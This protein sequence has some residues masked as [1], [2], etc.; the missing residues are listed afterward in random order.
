MT[1]SFRDSSILVVM[2][3]MVSHPRPRTIGRTAF[4]LSPIPLKTLSTITASLGRYPE[5]SRKLKNTKKK[6]TMGST[7][8]MA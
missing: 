6:L 2:V 7:M 8:A 3:A 5:S 4:P 1:R